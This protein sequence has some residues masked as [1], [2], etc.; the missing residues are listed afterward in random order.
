MPDPL[1]LLAV[2]KLPLSTSGLHTKDLGT[3]FN[4]GCTPQG[5]SLLTKHLVAE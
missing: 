5:F 2:V 4:S 1:V 3:F